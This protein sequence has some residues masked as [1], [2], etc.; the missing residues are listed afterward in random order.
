MRS[1][2][3]I[4]LLLLTAIP[5]RADTYRRQPGVDVLHYA[6]FV[7]LSDASDGISGRTQIQLA[8]REDDVPQVELDLADM[9]VDSI[10]VGGTETEFSAAGERVTI[11]LDPPR[12]RGDIVT[13]EVRYHGR[14]LAGLTIGK[15][16]F[17]R[18]VYFAENWPDHAH[19]WFPC[20][21]HPSDKATADVTVTADARYDVVAPG[22]LVERR[23]LLDG[24]RITH[25]SEHAPLPTYCVVFGAAEFAVRNA[26]TVNG[27]P[28]SWY[29]YP[30]DAGTAARLFQRCSLA[31]QFF[32]ERI[33]PY[34]FEKLAQVE[35]TT[36]I[37]GMENS[38]AIFYAESVFR[39][40]PASDRV[41]AHELAHQWFGDSVTESDWDHL[42]LS[43]GFATYFEALFYEHLEG[44]ESLKRSMSD[45]AAAVMAYHRINPAPV[46]DPN[47]RDLTKKLNAINYQKGA[48]ILHMLR[49]ML[50][51]DT[52]FKA[53]RRYYDLYAGSSV[54]S[55]E[56]ARVMEN[57]SGRPLADFFKQWLYQPGWPEYRIS[58]NWNQDAAEVELTV[59]QTQETGLFDMPLEIEFQFGNRRDRHTVQVSSAVHS[60][61]L[62]AEARPTAV[63][64]DPDG[65]LLKSCTV[66]RRQGH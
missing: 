66:E 15:N 55:S 34:P 22:A 30:D 51:D 24:R 56:F 27:V 25:W 5:G 39:A 43:E 64:C 50:G 1:A 28:V 18:R 26:G 21:D 9:S 17:G 32:T 54:L 60:V 53:V 41:V 12:R 45:S 33:G 38:S 49:R 46:I 37:G 11:P 20:I 63:I 19:H 13:V 52:F 65:W 6:L 31:M 44:P 7:E 58:W 57:M 23:S 59:R 35:S 47:T 16:G 42:W 2:A 14:P 40:N 3:T 10:I 48:W 36:K 62:P 61:S 4:F 8:L 29:V